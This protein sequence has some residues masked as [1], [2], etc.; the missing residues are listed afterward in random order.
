MESHSVVTNLQVIV[1]AT[2][3]W[4]SII[5][6]CLPRYHAYSRK[7]NRAFNFRDKKDSSQKSVCH[8]LAM[9]KVLFSGGLAP[10]DPVSTPVIIIGQQPH[11]NRVNWD[12]IKVSC[13]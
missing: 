2:M 6:F 9:A 10:C 3:T 5:M 4:H 1:F 12:D 7:D 11:L 13:H 8:G